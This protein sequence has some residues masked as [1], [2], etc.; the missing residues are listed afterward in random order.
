MTGEVTKGELRSIP[1]HK[2]FKLWI[3]NGPDKFVKFDSVYG[4]HFVCWYAN[5]GFIIQ[6]RSTSLHI[7]NCIQ[8]LLLW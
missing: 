5:P 3:E 6:L 8:T 1:K 4:G 2:L 7:L